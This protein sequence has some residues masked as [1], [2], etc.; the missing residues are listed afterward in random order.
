MIRFSSHSR[1]IR[2]ARARCVCV[3]PCIHANARVSRVVFFTARA[4]IDRSNATSRASRGR[5][6]NAARLRMRSERAWMGWMDDRHQTCRA[7][8][9]TAHLD[10]MR[11]CERVETARENSDDDFARVCVHRRRRR[12]ARAGTM[13][14]AMIARATPRSI[15]LPEET[16][17][18]SRARRRRARRPIDRFARRE[19]ISSSPRACSRGRRR[20]RCDEDSRARRRMRARARAALTRLTADARDVAFEARASALERG[21]STKKSTSSSSSSSSTASID[22]TRDRW[23][24]RGGSS[25]EVIARRARSYLHRRRRRR[26]ATT[27]TTTTSDDDENIDASLDAAARFLHRAWASGPPSTRETSSRTS[28][29][30]CSHRFDVGRRDVGARGIRRARAH[31]HR[32]RPPRRLPPRLPPRRRRRRPRRRR[33]V[34]AGPMGRRDARQSARASSLGSTIDENSTTRSSSAMRFAKRRR[35]VA[36]GV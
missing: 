19:S 34:A 7:A 26:R 5:R 31:S 32:A 10:A 21:C 12:I 29:D 3:H 23:R 9:S 27:T 6:V 15:H 16:T 17:T 11:R 13:D 1:A 20:A 8:S 18:S 2:D 36:S 35:H 4:R 30:R 24:R 25:I 14:D 22:A 33:C 28:F